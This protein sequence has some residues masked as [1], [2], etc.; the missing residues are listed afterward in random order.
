MCAHQA[1]AM[2][3]SKGL[4]L[5]DQNCDGAGCQ[6]NKRAVWTRLPCEV[7]AL[8]V[9]AR[10]GDPVSYTEALEVAAT[11]PA[12]SVLANHQN[13][14]QPAPVTMKLIMLGGLTMVGVF[15]VLRKG[16]KVCMVLL[17]KT[18]TQS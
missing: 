2:C 16:L 1:E 9:F 18:R 8:P 3:N 7:T 11:S 12:K 14:S 17:N 15:A 5:C 10:K 13:S 6:Y 4:R